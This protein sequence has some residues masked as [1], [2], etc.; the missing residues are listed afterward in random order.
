MKLRREPTTTS[1]KT[2][3]RRREAISIRMDVTFSLGLLLLLFTYTVNNLCRHIAKIRNMMLF[4]SHS[5]EIKKSPCCILG[6]LCH[7]IFD[8]REKCKT[9]VCGPLKRLKS[10]L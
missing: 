9:F 4:L 6:T 3:E 7:L 10:V 1:I 5:M 8:E 2:N